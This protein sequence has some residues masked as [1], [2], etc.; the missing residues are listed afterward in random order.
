VSKKCAPKDLFTFAS[1]DVIPGKMENIH[2]LTD[3]SSENAECRSFGFLVDEK[4]Q[5]KWLSLVE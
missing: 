4:Q 3:S 1:D 5:K 2:L